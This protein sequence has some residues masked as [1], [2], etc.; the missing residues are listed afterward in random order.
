MSFSCAR[1]P[2]A[3]KPHRCQECGREIEPGEHYERVAATWEGEFFTNVA[4]AHCA[5]ARMIVDDY[6]NWYHEGYYGGLGPWLDEE[7]DAKPWSQDLL[8]AFRVRWRGPGGDLLPLPT[9]T[10]AY[11]QERIEQRWCA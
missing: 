8:A 6:D 3:R 9:T 1:R 4:C 11:L 7:G 5:V 10:W 2:K